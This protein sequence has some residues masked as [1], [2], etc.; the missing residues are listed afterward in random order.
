MI[1]RGAG[2]DFLN[3][4]RSWWALSTRPREGR[5]RLVV[6]L[7]EVLEHRLAFSGLTSLT[8][9]F[10]R[11]GI[12]KDGTPFSTSGGL[13]GNGN[14]LSSAQVGSAITWNN[15][16]FDLGPA[17]TN[18]VVSAAGQTINL[19]AGNDTALSFLATAVN[20]NQPDQ[21]FTITWTDGTTQVFTQSISDWFTPQSYPGESIAAAT[22]YRDTFAG[23][24]DV[25][26]FNVYGYRFALDNTKTVES[27]TLPTNSNVELLGMALTPTVIVQDAGG[28]FNG[29]PFPATGIVNGGSSLE[30]VG[31]AFTW[32]SGNSPGGTP[33]SGPPRNAG[34][35]TVV[36]SFAGTS[37]AYT[38]SSDTRTFRITPAALTV[39]VNDTSKMSG[40]PLPA[41]SVHYSG[42]VHGDGPSALGGNLVFTTTATVDSQPGSVFL[43]TPSGLTSND[44][45]ITFVSGHL[46]V[47]PAS[48]AVTPL[49]AVRGPAQPSVPPTIQ[50]DTLLPSILMAVSDGKGFPNRAIAVFTDTGPAS[51]PMVLPTTLALSSLG[52]GLPVPGNPSGGGG[53]SATSDGTEY[54]SQARSGPPT[55]SAASAPA[56]AA[57]DTG[58]RASSAAVTGAS[59]RDEEE[60]EEQDRVF[61]LVGASDLYQ[62]KDLFGELLAAPV[63]GE[64]EFFP[65]TQPAEDGNDAAVVTATWFILATVACEVSMFAATSR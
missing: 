26:P 21:T 56:T 50:V 31:L 30:G 51:S 60:Q 39:T 55:A 42:F 15:A 65:W 14:A 49:G 35:Y 25:R 7:L 11:I 36:A 1:G 59:G 20:G 32:Y 61:T 52:N 16:S 40:A 58:Q 44:Y 38:P 28:V 2:R 3:G 37:G 23:G 53:G 19:P 57:F 29:S 6:P 9:A 17:N 45:S 18:N 48:A 54:S 10:N 13:D 64:M 62:E 22:V 8:S 12:Y 41:F 24:V 46:T 33:L 43:V 34:L 5:V 27:I 47:L 4:L 63:Q